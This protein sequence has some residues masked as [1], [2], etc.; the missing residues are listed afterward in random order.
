VPSA[1][2]ELPSGGDLQTSC[3]DSLDDGTGHD[4]AGVELVRQGDVLVAA[5]TLVAPPVSG[6]SF[7]TV[8]LDTPDGTALRQL[9]IELDGS[10]AV[11]AYV[12]SSPDDVQRLDGTVHVDGAEVHAAFPASVLEGLG[13][14][15]RWTAGVGTETTVQDI[16]PGSGAGP[17]APIVVP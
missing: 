15:W 12:A 11:A 1:P 13:P 17:V 10:A 16:C 5:F 3:G 2:T 9:G 6:D 4:I 14:G 8:Q 7:Y